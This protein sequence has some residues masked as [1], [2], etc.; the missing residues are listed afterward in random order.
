MYFYSPCATVLALFKN[1]Q[2]IIG[3]II[4]TSTGLY[5][6]LFFKGGS[7]PLWFATVIKIIFEIY[8]L[9]SLLYI[10]IANKLKCTEM[11][12]LQTCSNQRD[13]DDEEAAVELFSYDDSVDDDDE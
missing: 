5:I 12:K 2:L 10:I 6:Q 4:Q 9:A 13:D 11:C 7:L 3:T 8:I 1:I